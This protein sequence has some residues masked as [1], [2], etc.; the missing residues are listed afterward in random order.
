M[1]KSVV[2]AAAQGLVDLTKLDAKWLQKWKKTCRPDFI[3][4]R[5]LVPMKNNDKKMYSLTMFP[6][7]SGML[8]MGHL[9]VYTI[10]DV[11]ARHYRMQGLDLIHP[12]G[13]DA[14]GL[15][16]ENAA[17]ERGVN[18][19]DW[20]KINM[21]KMKDQM[22]L[23]NTDFDWT[24]ELATCDPNY[25]KWT[26][27]IFLELHK[28]GLAYRKKAE[29]NWDPID[30]TVLANEQVD[31]EGRSWRSGAIVEKRLLEQ[32]FLGI[33]KY[34]SELN[35]DLDLL[36]DWPSKVRTMQRNWI[37][38]SK[39]TDIQFPISST[40]D[41][42]LPMNELDAFTTRAETI[43]SV[44][45]VAIGFDH[46][47]TQMVANSNEKLREFIDR[48]NK[49][50]EEAQKSK[51]GFLLDDVFAI[52]PLDS[53][54]QLPIF[55]APY[56]ISTYGS[57]SVMG[58]PAHDTR[59]FEFWLQNMGS[60]AAII[61]TVSPKESS[62]EPADNEPFI[63]KEGI[64]NINSRFLQ[65]LST[66]DAR[67]KVTE[68]LKLINKGEFK[69][70]YRIRD[71]LISR[72]R[73]WGAP[74]P[75]IHCESCGIVPVPDED[76]PV[77]LP[78]LDY[79]PSRGGS[80]LAQVE[81]FVNCECPQ[82]HKPAKRDTDTM[83]TFIDSSWYMFRFLDPNN[84]EKAF[85]KEIASKYMPVD[86]YIGG[87]EH[88]ILHL[89]YS[90]FISKFLADAGWF[91]KGENWKGEP[92]KQLITQG[93]V[94]GK[95]FVNPKTGKFLKPD[96]YDLQ[97]DGN[98]ILKETGAIA[99]ISFE[100]MSKSKYNGA[101]PGEC[102]VAHGADA[103]RAHV[104]FQAPI[105]DV[106]D[107]NEAKIV[108]IERWLKKVL[109][110]SVDISSETKAVIVDEIDPVSNAELELHNE[111]VKLEQSIDDS[112]VG[113]LSF[114][115]LISSYMK[116]NNALIAGFK[117]NEVRREYIAGKFVKMVKY[118]CPVTPSV[119]EEVWEL[120]HE[121]STESEITDVESILKA[122][123][124]I[125]SE[126][127]QTKIDY[128][129]MINGKMKFIHSTKTEYNPKEIEKC[130]SEVQKHESASK[131]FSGKEI[132]KT[133]IKKDAIIFILK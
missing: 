76:L 36:Q 26:Q 112:F 95:T 97:A 85:S 127:F 90:R 68:E 122:D 10:S 46:P 49:Q 118:M 120:F 92:F 12:M 50:G 108:G 19:E 88:A 45:Y 109:K 28:H 132:K 41:M 130:I 39:G 111:L 42:E 22:V 31:S 72:Q 105:N 9:R 8:H 1:A 54:I 13:W 20:T 102:I 75:M 74:I 27:K 79:I 104:L 18:P 7:P 84:N 6:Y 14:F 3:N 107:W 56:V 51:D 5:R 116:Y 115:T 126:L 40:N 25:Y 117:D 119:C 33:T 61:H 60:D 114:N 17:V 96:E 98:A 23:M 123:W 110:L 64:M 82:C 70:N 65:D 78:H 106:L 44:Q 124:P 35:K 131:L 43:F 57:G 86:Q 77:K 24:R 52:N 89:L 59:D 99:N 29:I 62:N 63:E 103:T 2:A 32:W 38:E 94:H 121:A 30:N 93:M 73:Y 113:E 37:G 100:K 47:I 133:I 125:A 69:T 101:D 16:A 66:A 129:V 83:D 53:N 34:A 87:V 71:W 80:P 128:K 91:E 21:Q 15:P 81:E 58:C 11:L 67:K 55:V 4:P 48:L